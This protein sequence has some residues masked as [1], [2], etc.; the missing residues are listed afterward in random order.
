MIVLEALLSWAGSLVTAMIVAMV[1]SFIAPDDDSQKPIKLIIALFVLVSF[2]MP[3]TS[4]ELPGLDEVK[5]F[6]EYVENSALEDSVENYA[7]DLLSA[8]IV[9]SITAYL[10]NIGINSS[11]I[12]V[13]IDIDDE[14]NISVKSITVKLNGSDLQK[15]SGLN[16]FCS[17]NYGVKPIIKDNGG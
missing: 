2:F 3:F 12:S 10:K 17:E 16:G 13:N 5:G 4:V 15:V 9:S 6:D 7:A 14:K 11:D 8:Q 1:V